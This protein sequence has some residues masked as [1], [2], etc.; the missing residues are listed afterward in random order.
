M[1]YLLCLFRCPRHVLFRPT[2]IATGYLLAQ[3]LDQFLRTG[4]LAGTCGDGTT[5]LF[6]P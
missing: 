4:S 2:A 5:A 3:L 1:N 6:C